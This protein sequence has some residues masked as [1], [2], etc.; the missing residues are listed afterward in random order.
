MTDDEIRERIDDLV[1]RWHDGEW[2][3]SPLR[4]ILGMDGP[5]YAAFAE[6]GELPAGYV[7]P[8]RPIVPPP[9]RLFGRP[10]KTT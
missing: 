5:Q 2:E 4:D 9:P 8:D 3:G 1:D 10:R 6:R 7:V